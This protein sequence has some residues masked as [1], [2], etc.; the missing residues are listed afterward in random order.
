MNDRYKRHN[1]L[2]GFGEKSQQKL[3]NSSVLVIGAGGLGSPLLMYLAASGV[4]RIGIVDDDKVSLSNLQRQI[5]YTEEDLGKSK[6]ETAGLR[7][8]KMNSDINFSIYETRINSD[9]ISEIIKNYDVVVDA[10]DN[11]KSKFLIN[12][13]CVKNKIP[14]IHGGVIGWKGQVLTVLPGQ[15]ACYRCVFSE[16]PP[17]SVIL[18]QQNQG[19]YSPLVGMIGTIQASEVIKLLSGI[20]CLYTDKI[21]TVDLNSGVIRS[22]KL[23]INL[24]CKAC[25]ID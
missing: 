21:F 5:I 6:A 14:F 2:N 24:D 17:D 11:F 25:F 15:S 8:K 12:D 4:G 20:R 13:F 22:I 10:V 7:L 1:I 3:S 19:V 18:D 23:R 16:E 9:N